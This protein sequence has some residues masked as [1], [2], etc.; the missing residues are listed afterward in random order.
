MGVGDSTRGRPRR[1]SRHDIEQTAIELFLRDGYSDTSIE[2]IA[3]ACGISK[4]TYFRYYGSKSEL[5]WWVFDEYIGATADA[6]AAADSTLEVMDAV[7]V[8]L[9]EATRGVSDDSGTLMKRFTLLDTTPEL[10]EGEA[11]HWHAW[12]E[13][14]SRFVASR[15]GMPTIGVVPAAVGGALQAAYLAGF[16]ESAALAESTEDTLA[17]LDHA[18]VLL[19]PSLRT[20][21]G[22]G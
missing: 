20:L 9:A 7:R 1:S 13:A 6:L 3:T 15:T 2:A 11:A 8:A 16:R 14:I 19:S 4:T 5:V 22:E 18:V 21:I 10:K 12:G 17:R